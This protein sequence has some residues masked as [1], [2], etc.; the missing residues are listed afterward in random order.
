MVWKARQRHRVRHHNSPTTGA[1]RSPH[2]ARGFWRKGA[3]LHESGGG[4]TEGATTNRT[5]LTTPGFNL[6]NSCFLRNRKSW[7]DGFFICPGE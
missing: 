3:N 1:A 6:R 2:R 7:S 4:G 5:H